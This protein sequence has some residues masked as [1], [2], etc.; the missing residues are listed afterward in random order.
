MKFRIFFAITVAT[1][2]GIVSAAEPD[3][4][5]LNALLAKHVRAG[6]KQGI[7]THLVDYRSLG[8]DPL[9]NEA[10]N[11]MQNFDVRLL[12][13]GREKKAFYI[14]AYN[15]A[16]IKKVLEKY[17]TGSIR[18]TGDGVWKENAI[19]LAGKPWSLDAIENQILRKTGDARIHFAIV[20]ASLSCPDLRREAYTALRLEKQLE[21]QT[22]AFL[23]NPTKGVRVEQGRIYHSS[24]FNWFAA[25]FKDVRAFQR[26]YLKNLPQTTEST[27]ISYNWQLNE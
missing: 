17:P 21:S 22:R 4:K 11:V 2:T 7:T 18:A 24:I 5:A 19:T 10:L 27:E 6:N 16:A 1:A 12:A 14:N 3:Y 20:C 13:N 26:R 15:V 23:V 8:K 9:Y 25:D